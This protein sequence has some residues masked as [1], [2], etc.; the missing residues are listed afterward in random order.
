MTVLVASSALTKIARWPKRLNTTVFLFLPER[1]PLPLIVS[2]SPTPTCIGVTFVMTGYFGPDLATAV[3]AGTARTAAAERAR[4]VMVRTRRK[5]MPGPHIGAWTNCLRT[6]VAAWTRFAGSETGP[7]A[8]TLRAAAA[9]RVGTRE[10]SDLAR[11]A[12]RRG[13]VDG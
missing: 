8:Q 11:E 13:P 1:K 9:I 10:H 6:F 3:P 5:D 2:R 12:L 4:V 7:D